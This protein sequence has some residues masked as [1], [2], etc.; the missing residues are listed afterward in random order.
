MFV[1]GE[2]R[3][4]YHRRNVGGKK[5]CILGCVGNYSAMVRRSLGDC[6]RRL[7]DFLD[8]FVELF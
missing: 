1:F 4:K 3:N 2:Y 6:G 7:D 5:S 8:M